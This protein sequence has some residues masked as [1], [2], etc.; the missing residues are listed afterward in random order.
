[1]CLVGPHR[2]DLELRA[3]RRARPRGTRATA[4]RGR[5]RSRCGWRPTGCCA[6]R[7]RAGADPRRRVRRA[8]RPAPP[9]AGR[10]RPRAP[11]RCW[12]PPRSR[13][14]A[15]PASAGVRFT[16]SGGRIERS[17]SSPQTATSC[18]RRDRYG[19]GTRLWIL[20]T[21][22]AAL[23]M[24]QRKRPPVDRADRPSRGPGVVPRP[25]DR[26][27]PTAGASVPTRTPRQTPFRSPIGRTPTP[28]G[29]ISPARRCARPARRRRP[30]APSGRPRRSGV[31]R[32]SRG[33][34]RRWSGP[35]PDDRDPQPFGRLVA[36]R[37]AGPRVVAAAD[38]R[39]GP[40]ALAAARR[41]GHR[42]PLHPAVAA[43]RRARAAGRVDGV[44]H[45]AAHP[46]APA[47]A[48]DRRGRSART[49]CGGSAWSGPS[50]PSWRHGPRARPGTGPARHVRLSRPRVRCRTH[51]PGSARR[52][53]ARSARH[54]VRC[55]RRDPPIGRSLPISSPIG[56]QRGR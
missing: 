29:P 6:R 42:R 20:W 1:M 12:S 31:A 40:R 45:P 4:S 49:S 47:A 36:R 44:G 5:W 26:G 15:R 19:L 41:L 56:R 22:P 51:D 50:G 27:R 53:D 30:A 55:A 21:T 25:G 14:R 34:R 8:G 54:D 3:R 48:P 38:R 52:P 39:D 18:P 16:V 2:D 33:R 23:V 10:G 32:R 11:S 24:T 43:R 17:G 37:V 7:R 28:E 35:G 13:G 9:R 46:V